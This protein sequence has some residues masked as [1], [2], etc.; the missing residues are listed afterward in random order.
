MT[1]RPRVDHRL[2]RP[3]QIAG[4]A[5]QTGSHGNRDRYHAAK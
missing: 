2:L 4:R 5:V 1:I 3:E